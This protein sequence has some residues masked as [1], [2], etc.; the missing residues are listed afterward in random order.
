MAIR[1]DERPLIA[2][3]DLPARVPNHGDAE[4][5]LDAGVV[6]LRLERVPEEDQKVDRACGNER[7]ELMIV[8]ERTA[9]HTLQAKT[10]ALLK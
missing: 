10:D 5:R 4:Q 8:T 9:L 2:M 1:S 6:R 7:L 3:M